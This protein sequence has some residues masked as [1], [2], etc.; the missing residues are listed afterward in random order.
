MNG[1]ESGSDRKK[2]FEAE[3]TFSMKCQYNYQPLFFE[4]L[5]SWIID[6]LLT[7]A[8]PK[9]VYKLDINNHK[10]YQMKKI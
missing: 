8:H 3:I 10:Q 9:F 4:S 5:F 2:T 6:F 7:H 1:S